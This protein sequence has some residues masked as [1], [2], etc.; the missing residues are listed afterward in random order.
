M[1]TNDQLKLIT[2]IYAYAN[3]FSKHAVGG[4]HHFSPALHLIP[5]ILIHEQVETRTLFSMTLVSLQLLLALQLME[6]RSP[7]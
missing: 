7:K 2:K 6:L 1:I 4:K 3:D 5:K